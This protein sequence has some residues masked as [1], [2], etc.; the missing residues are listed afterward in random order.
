M[1]AISI[2]QLIQCLAQTLL[3]ILIAPILDGLMR[4]ITARIQNR[5]GPPLLQSMYDLL[6]LLGKEDLEASEVP[7]IQR[8]SAYGALGVVLFMSCVIPLGIPAAFRTE[9]DV[10]LIIHLLTMAALS[11]IFAGLAT[12]NIFSMLGINREI[13]LMM[14]LE[15]LLALAIFVGIVHTQSFAIDAVLSGGIY[16]S[17]RFPLSALMMLTLIS[18]AFPAYLQKAPFNLSEAETEVIEGPLLEY[19]GPKLAL[20]K[21]A[22]MIRTVLYAALFVNIFLPW[23]LELS[24]G[25]EW[26]LFWAKVVIVLIIFTIVAAVYARYRIDQSLRWLGTMLVIGAIGLYLAGCGW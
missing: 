2:I 22:Y 25:I 9:A 10:L 13:M 23:G 26:L 20:F 7:L 3:L 11:N 17:Q 5:Q 19:S 4:R 12:G 21:L 6:K 14:I 8:L 16:M 1:K 24:K 18:A 15:P